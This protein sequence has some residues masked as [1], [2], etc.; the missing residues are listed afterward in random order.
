MNP[1][2]RR[3][4]V[5]GLPQEV[6]SKCKLIVTT[7]GSISDGEIVEGMS[8][9]QRCQTNVSID[10]VGHLSEYIRHGA[11]WGETEAT[12]D[13][14]ASRGFDVRLEIAIQAYNVFDLPDIADY[15]CRMG[16]VLDFNWVF[17]PYMLDANVLPS[18]ARAAC[19]AKISGVHNSFCG[20]TN[21]TG[22]IKSVRSADAML[23]YT[24]SR[25][26]ADDGLDPERG[27]V[28]FCKYTR[29]LDESRGE[30][31]E[32]RAPELYAAISKARAFR[33]HYLRS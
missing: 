4:I 3:L 28:G 6:A 9:F 1:V 29:A 8:R 30:R 32:E 11:K 16:R 18:S 24:M 13:R 10:G 23:K 25:L 5:E 22:K 7:N 12:I 2:L 31:L 27:F 15:S 21:A 33:E 14:F 20:D 26:K 17:R 19:L